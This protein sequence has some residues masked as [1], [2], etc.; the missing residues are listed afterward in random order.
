M[1][2]VTGAAGF[3]GSNLVDRL[4]GEGH[5]VVGYDN[6]STGQRSFLD[7]AAAS[8]NFRLIEGDLLDTITLTEAM[9]GCDLVYHLAANADARFGAQHPRKDLEQN[10]IATSNVLKAMRATGALRVAFSSTGSVYTGK[11]KS[12]PRPST[13]HFRFRHRFME[14]QSSDAKG[15]SLTTVRV[16]AFKEPCFVLFQFWESATRTDMSLIFTSACLKTRGSCM[17]LA[18]DSSASNTSD[19]QDCLDAMLTAIEKTKAQFDV[20]QFSE[21]KSI[22]RFN[23]SISWICE[24]LGLSLELTYSGG[25]RGWIGDSPF[26]F[27]DCTKIWSLG[28]KPRLTIREAVLRTVDYLRDNRCLLGSEGMMRMCVH[29][30]S[31]HHLLSHAAADGAPRR[32]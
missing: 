22:A 11:P 4:L 2:F 6:F 13:S 12:F 8:P 18:T 32:Q 30:L 5:Q 14:R 3:I 21:R 17:F 29:G 1:I 15:S 19:I 27:L 24:H 28:W 7:S 31:H 26:I 16:S 20:L 9:Q 23:H 25:A 10:T